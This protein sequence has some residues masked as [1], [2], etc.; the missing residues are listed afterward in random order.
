MTTRKIIVGYDRSADAMN[1]ARWALD[2]A[3][4]TGAPVELFYAFEWPVWTPSAPFIPAGAVWPDGETERV[5][6]E[7]LQ[8][9]LAEIRRTH[10]AVPCTLQTADGN[11]A[12]MLVQRSADAGLVVLGSRGHSAVLNMLGNVGVAVTAH[13]HCP[14]VV[15]RGRPAADASVAVGFDGSPAAEAAL[16]FAA[17]QATARGVALRVVQAFKPAGATGAVQVEDSR[18]LEELAARWQAKFPQLALRAEAVAEHPAI[19]LTKAGSTAQLLVVGSRGRG[20][21]KG[22]LLGSVSQHLLRN[23][24]CSIA[25]VHDT[26]A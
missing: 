18:R 2:E 11:A 1:A 26:A 12:L 13:A 6:Q 14:V 20:P 5:I 4:R 25:V 8:E 7:G 17:E 9:A 23:S 3:E 10:P 21:L 15:V 16:A 19:A 24:E 22:M